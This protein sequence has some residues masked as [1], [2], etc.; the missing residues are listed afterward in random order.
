MGR[1]VLDGGEELVVRLALFAAVALAACAHTQN[2][3]E[4]TPP[5]TGPPC[6]SCKE[7]SSRDA[8]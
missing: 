5:G 7:E 8:R 6:P 1:R 2:G 3:E 4:E